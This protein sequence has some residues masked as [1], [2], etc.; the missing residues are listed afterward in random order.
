MLHLRLL[1]CTLTLAA[2]SAAA[3]GPPP[4]LV[5]V[6]KGD[7]TGP[8]AEVDMMGYAQPTQKAGGLHLRLFARAFIAADPAAPDKKVCFVS[9]DAGMPSAAIKIALTKKLSAKF[10]DR[11]YNERNVMISGTHTH[12]GPSGFFEYALFDLAGSMHVNG[13]RSHPV[14]PAWYRVSALGDPTAAVPRAA[15][16]TAFVDGIFDAIVA[17][18]ANLGPASISVA[19]GEVT[20][21][22]INRSPSSYLRNPAAERSRY[23][24]DTDTQ[25]GELPA[26]GC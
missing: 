1:L 7:I 8:I 16:A 21:G 17:A 11:R 25:L 26:S 10:P 12:S 23:A 4:F 20:D 18:D 9:M 22:N 5:G 3:A 14:V 15:T 24:G 6:G 13:A 2:V 19:A